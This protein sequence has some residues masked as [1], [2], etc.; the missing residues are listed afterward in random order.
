MVLNVFFVIELVQCHETVSLDGGLIKI[1]YIGI[2][3]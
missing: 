2:K 3:S 1:F